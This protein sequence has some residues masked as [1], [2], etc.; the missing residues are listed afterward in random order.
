MNA[1]TRRPGDRAYVP[2]VGVEQQ[3]RRSALNTVATWAASTVFLGCAMAWPTARVGLAAADR[4][5]VLAMKWS[6]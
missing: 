3:P 5:E 6:A 2:G 1:A 4:L